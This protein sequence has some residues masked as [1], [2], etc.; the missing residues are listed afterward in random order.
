[1]GGGKRGGGGGVRRKTGGWGAGREVGWSER[2]SPASSGQ[3]R[4]RAPPGE[5]R[6][7]HNARRLPVAPG[8]TPR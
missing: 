7:P 4:F 6:T 1:M 2:T 3:F 8:L 5:R